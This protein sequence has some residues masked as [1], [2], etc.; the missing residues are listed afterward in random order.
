MRMLLSAG[1]GSSSLLLS[2]RGR[3]AEC[4]PKLRPESHAQRGTDALSMG[5]PHFSP[6]FVAR[7]R[8]A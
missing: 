5:E 4:N 2:R 3:K 1:I 7:S 6:P 8:M